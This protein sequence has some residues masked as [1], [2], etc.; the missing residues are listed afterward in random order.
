MLD[1]AIRRGPKPDAIARVSESQSLAVVTTIADKWFLFFFWNKVCSWFNSFWWSVLRHYFTPRLNRVDPRDTAL[2]AAGISQCIF[3]TCQIPEKSIST[4]HAKK[5]SSKKH[6]R[7][8]ALGDLPTRD[9]LIRVL[10]PG[11]QIP[12]S[13]LPSASV[14]CPPAFSCWGK[15]CP[16]LWDLSTW[17]EITLSKE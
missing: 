5:S 1:F 2:G 8:K 3:T 7:T 17:F 14:T 9:S 10:F 11:W 6:S 13:Q 15:D 12:R 16:Y 4:K